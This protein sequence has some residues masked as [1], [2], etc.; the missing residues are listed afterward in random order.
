MSENWQIRLLKKE[1]PEYLNCKPFFLILREFDNRRIAP[2][3]E[4]PED[5]E[6]VL[7]KNFIKENNESK[8]PKDFI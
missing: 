6:W 8:D 3:G 1:V 4:D 5:N 2:D 7:L